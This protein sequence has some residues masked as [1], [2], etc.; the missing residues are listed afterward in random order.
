MFPTIHL[1]HSDQLLNE[2]QKKSSSLFKT[3]TR[4][5]LPFDSLDCQ[6]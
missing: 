5:N 4:K 6:L 3:I 1:F 2:S